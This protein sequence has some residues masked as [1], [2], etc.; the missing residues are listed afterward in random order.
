M[1]TSHKSWW[2]GRARHGSGQYFM[3]TSLPWMIASALFRMTRPPFVIGGVAM[4]HGYLRGFLTRAPRY[5]DDEFRRFLR[6][7]QVQCLIKG[8]QRA[9]AELNARQAGRWDPARLPAPALGLLR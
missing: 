8:K 4:L 1:G 5:G 3:G 6:R 9:T 2:T 7:Y